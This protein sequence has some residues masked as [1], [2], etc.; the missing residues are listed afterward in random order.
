MPMPYAV[1]LRFFLACCLLAG[2]SSLPAGAAVEAAG[3]HNIPLWQAIRIGNGWKV[4]IEVSDPDCPYSRRMVRYWDLRRDVTRYVFLIA[5]KNHPEAEVKARYILSAADRA[6]AYRQVYTGQL[7][8]EEQLLERRYDD[9][10]LFEK[11][12]AVAAGLGVT[13]TPT[14]FIRG[15]RVNGARLG[16]IE[17]LLGGKK[18]PFKAGDAE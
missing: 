16:E 1:M 13:G 8:F 18:Y 11:H 2:G 4:V 3:L 5:L 7:D 14:Y 9:H 10:G 17:Q 12:R 15:V 6:T